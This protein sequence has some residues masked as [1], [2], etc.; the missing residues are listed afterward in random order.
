MLRYIINKVPISWKNKYI[1]I[2]IWWNQANSELGVIFSI[3][4]RLMLALLLFN[5]FGWNMMY[6]I[7]LGIIFVIFTFYIGWGLV[8]TNF[9]AHKTSR[10]NRYNPEIMEILERVKNI[11]KR[12]K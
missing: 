7:P 1:D 10:T 3:Y 5:A 11:E 8:V 4:E 9:K 6:L 2:C 12:L